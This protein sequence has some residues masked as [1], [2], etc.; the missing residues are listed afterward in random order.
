MRAPNTLAFKRWFRQSVVL[1]PEGKP[2]VV[3]HGTE[4]RFRTP[5]FRPGKYGVYGAGLYFTDDIQEAGLYAGSQGLVVPV[6]LSIQNPIGLADAR[7]IEQMVGPTGAAMGREIRSKGFDGIVSGGHYVVYDPR[8]VKS[9]L[10][11]RGT[12]DPKDL[13]FLNGWSL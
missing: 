4:K 9:A 1:T 11:N 5:V 13:N 3:Y 12:F 2:K 8:Q 10:G 7:D 6:F